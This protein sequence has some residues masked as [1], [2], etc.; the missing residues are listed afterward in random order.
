MSGDRRGVGN[1]KTWGSVLAKL[2]FFQEYHNWTT[3]LLGRF[4]QS[5]VTECGATQ[6]V[7]TY[8]NDYDDPPE[9][10]GGTVTYKAKSS[11]S[12]LDNGGP[13]EAVSGD[14]SAIEVRDHNDALIMTIT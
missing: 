10:A 13:L 4:E 7:L 8:P 6:L 14:V 9:L 1:S 12:Y 5:D 3:G 11:F 2:K